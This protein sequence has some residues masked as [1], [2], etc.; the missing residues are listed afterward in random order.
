MPFTLS[1]VAAALPFRTRGR[2]ALPFAALAAGSMAP[3]LPYFV[4]GLR[5]LGPATHTLAAVPTWDLV[6]GLAMWL[7][8]RLVAPGLWR[9]APMPVRERWDPRKG[10]GYPW[11]R[12]LLAL[13][14]GT[15]THVLWDEFTHL[16]RFGTEHLAV[17]TTVFPS[18][19]GPLPGYR[20]A[21]YLSGV[22]GLAALL[23]VARRRE[24]RPVGAADLP[25][26]S[27]ALPWLVVGAVAFGAALRLGLR[28]GTVD[29]LREAV[30][31][32]IT[33]GGAAAGVVLLLV[34]LG[35]RWWPGVR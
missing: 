10:T 2:W 31:V 22:L 11:W 6:L 19:L 7:T 35:A 24:R 33:G 5:R 15:A 9:V 34:G 25:R 8:W 29:G 14:I 30:F 28:S 16:G 18:P 17:L 20:W 32:A 27:A 23:L 12:V 4:A 1:H 13:L 21:Q 26:L 3:D